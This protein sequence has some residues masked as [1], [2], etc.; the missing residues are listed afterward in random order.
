MLQSTIAGASRQPGKHM[1]LRYLVPHS[2]VF[3]FLWHARQVVMLAGKRHSV[4]FPLEEFFLASVVHSV[5]HYAVFRAIDGHR[6]SWGKDLTG[7]E[8]T[9]KLNLFVSIYAAPAQALF[10]NMLKD[11]THVTPF[12]KDIYEGFLEIDEELANIVTLSLSY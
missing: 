6:L 9:G 4:P 5:D 3:N 12:Y 1:H 7:V 11:F 8:H 2:D 10:S